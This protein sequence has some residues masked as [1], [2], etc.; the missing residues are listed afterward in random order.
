M[1][2]EI[3]MF[4]RLFIKFW[5]RWIQRT[6]KRKARLVRSADL[7]RS[8]FLV[9]CSA[10]QSLHVLWHRTHHPYTHRQVLVNRISSRPISWSCRP[11]RPLLIRERL[12]SSSKEKSFPFHTI[13]IA[14]SLSS[15]TF[16]FSSSCLS[17][18]FSP[19]LSTKNVTTTRVSMW[20]HKD[21]REIKII[22]KSKKKWVLFLSEWISEY[23]NYSL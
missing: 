22:K 14:S 17:L 3:T 1:K 23:S 9:P 19:L 5:I 6:N 16:S 21:G 4:V 8:L 20:N 12:P 11:Q 13:R 18:S 10:F 15:S 2:R 7:V